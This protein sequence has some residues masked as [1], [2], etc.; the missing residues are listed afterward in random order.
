VTRDPT[1]DQGDKHM[2][3]PTPYSA[4]VVV[5][6]LKD[7]E[8]AGIIG[9]AYDPDTAMNILKMMSGTGNIF[10]ALIGMAQAIFGEPDIDA[11]HREVI[12]LRVASIL[13]C[14]YEWQAN[15]QLGRNAGL[16]TA[17]I[18]AVAGDRPVQDL[19]RDYQLLIAATDELVT[20]GTL[21]DDALQS[22]LD[23]FGATVARK[24]IATIA[25]FGFLCLFVN[26]TRVPMETTDKIGKRTSPLP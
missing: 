1:F 18:D 8:I 12:M 4:A 7:A 6:L 9:D 13:N 11:K 2:G 21:T 24:Y 25:W 17:E 10:P 16:T 23:T 5:P 3:K 14:P 26:G 15:E 19:D 20:S 22:V